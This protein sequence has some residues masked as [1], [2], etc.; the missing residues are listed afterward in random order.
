MDEKEIAKITNDAERDQAERDR[1]SGDK[2]GPGQP[3]KGRT[4]E[5]IEADKSREGGS[6]SGDDEG[7]DADE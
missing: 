3:I 5:E 6:E 4:P 7:D 1:A 2:G